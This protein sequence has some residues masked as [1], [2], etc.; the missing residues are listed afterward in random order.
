[1]L[2]NVLSSAAS[3]SSEHPLLAYIVPTE[4][5][6][7]I[8]IGQLVAIPY[9][10][11]LVE[12]L[13]W[14][15][16]T[17]STE[18]DFSPSSRGRDK[19]GP[20][21]TGNELSEDLSPLLGA[22]AVAPILRPIHAVLDPEPALLPHQIALAQWISAYYVT[23]LSQVA[24]MMLPPGL[25]QRSR[26]VLHLVEQ[27]SQA[28]ESAIGNTSLQTRA[29]IGLLLAEGELDVERPQDYARFKTS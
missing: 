2:V 3:W 11:R 26:T 5:E 14:E 22:P 28:I 25:M 20:Y 21:S 15:I 9:G 18:R 7:T 24:L 23:P 10:E 27:E 16:I 17:S 12:G 13:I 1:M 8:R 29:L 4:F 19:S 6:D